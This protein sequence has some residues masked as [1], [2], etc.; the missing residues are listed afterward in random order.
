MAAV[1]QDCQIV[2]TAASTTLTGD[3]PASIASGDLLL[4]NV[5]ALAQA[6]AGTITTPTGY[7]QLG[8]TVAG[9]FDFRR[10]VFY[11][12]ADGTESGTLSVTQSTAQNGMVMI[13]RITGAS[14]IDV[15]DVGNTSVTGATAD[16]DAVTTSA[17][18]ELVIIFINQYTDGSNAWGMTI[19]ATT[20]AAPGE[21]RL[22][23]NF[24]LCSGAAYFTQATAGSTGAKT[25]A[26]LYNNGQN[27]QTS[28]IA[29]TSAAAAAT[30]RTLMLMGVGS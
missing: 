10:G 13:A 8:S 19:P 9:T 23:Q 26:G 3:Y 11:K 28:T 4:V 16:S 22:Q 18:D 24:A 17:D 27:I 2:Y 30:A 25:W 7:T 1:I 5:C 21:D 14:G 12:I 15:H 20:F 29:I 6:T